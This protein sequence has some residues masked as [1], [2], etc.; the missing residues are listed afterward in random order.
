VTKYFWDQAGD[1][2]VAVR[3]VLSNALFY[4]NNGMFKGG[5]QILSNEGGQTTW[6]LPTMVG[7]DVVC[8]KQLPP[9]DSATPSASTS[10]SS[11]PLSLPSPSSTRM[12]FLDVLGQTFTYQGYRFRRVPLG[13]R[14]KTAASAQSACRQADVALMPLCARPRSVS[15]RLCLAVTA[16]LLFTPDSEWADPQEWPLR[17]VPEPLQQILNGGHFV[18]ASVP[19]TGRLRTNDGELP[20]WQRINAIG[21][22]VV[23]VKRL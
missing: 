15:S 22:D 18:E 14:K 5:V 13:G 7:G 19:D 6:S 12:P 17:D 21:G 20:F 1:L 2:N 3:T 16:S 4:G 23:C 9:T 8:A 11:S 10:V